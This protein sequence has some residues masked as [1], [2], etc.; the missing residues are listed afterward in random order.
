MPEPHPYHH[1][2]GAPSPRS[3]QINS[4]SY[5]ASND[6]M[7]LRRKVTTTSITAGRRLPP[8]PMYNG[9]RSPPAGPGRLPANGLPSDVR[10]ANR[11]KRTDSP[12][13]SISDSP[14]SAHSNRNQ[15]YG[16]A[17]W[18][19]PGGMNREDSDAIIRQ[20]SLRP[21]G[22]LAPKIPG[23]N[24]EAGG[25]TSSGLPS[26]SSDQHVEETVNN[27]LNGYHHTLAD[28]HQYPHMDSSP[29]MYNYAQATP[30]VPPNNQLYVPG[31]LPARVSQEHVKSL[32]EHGI[33]PSYSP[34]ATAACQSPI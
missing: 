17:D 4:D 33:S 11:I 23:H 14:I 19:P 28:S 5:T 12:S 30:P 25:E 29:P 27:K 9:N 10:P 20:T 34:D 8:A 13:G 24:Y 15:P 2:S 32:P 3:N 21:P 16:G 26:S 22:A 18:T 1:D 31:G 6:T 7:D